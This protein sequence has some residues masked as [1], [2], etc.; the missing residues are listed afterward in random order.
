MFQAE[1]AELKEATDAACDTAEGRAEE[2]EGALVAAQAELEVVRRETQAL[3]GEQQ[4]KFQ[5][6]EAALQA[7]TDKKVR[8][9]LHPKP[10][11]R[12]EVQALLGSSTS[13][14]GWRRRCRRRRTKRYGWWSLSRP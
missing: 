9:T 14:R 11:K 1:L 8:E 6:L 7:A 13:S 4:R 10:N 2:A 5:G 3:L 12:S